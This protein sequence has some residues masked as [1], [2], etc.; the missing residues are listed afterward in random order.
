MTMLIGI[1]YVT[2]QMIIAKVESYNTQNGVKRHGVCN[3]GWRQR[4]GFVGV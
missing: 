1:S 3:S 2:A 4:G